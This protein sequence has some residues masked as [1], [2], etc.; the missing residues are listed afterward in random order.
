[1]SPFPKRLRAARGFV[2]HLAAGSCVDAVL[3]GDTIKLPPQIR[4]AEYT[5][6]LLKAP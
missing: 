5:G 4:Q 3:A 2:R 1:M 6:V